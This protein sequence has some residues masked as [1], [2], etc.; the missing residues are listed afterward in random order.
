MRGHWVTPLLE[1]LLFATSWAY[2]YQ[3]GSLHIGD[4]EH[5]LV[6]ITA[7]GSTGVA[8][9]GPSESG[10]CS[11]GHGVI[12]VDFE[13]GLCPVTAV[14]LGFSSHFDVV[15]YTFSSQDVSQRRLVES[16]PLGAW[17]PPPSHE[18]QE[19]GLKLELPAEIG[20][21]PHA[22]TLSLE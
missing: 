4:G 13:S 8:A 7:R 21:D 11:L 5:G 3:P 1:S 10:K 14:V 12:A 17:Q 18:G 6:K 2:Q 20:V 22:F 19:F 9:L 15:H 16:A